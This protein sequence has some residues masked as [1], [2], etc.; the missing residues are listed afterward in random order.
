MF[1]LKELQKAIVN[2]DKSK[3]KEF[4][5]IISEIKN[6]VQILS[7]ALYPAIDEI[8]DSF[9]KK[10]IS[11]IELLLSLQIFQE[12]LSQI[13]KKSPLPA[14]KE[15]ILLGV[16]E[17]DVHDMG[18][19][20]IKEVYIC[21]GFDVYDVGKN[22]PINLFLEKIRSK[23][24]AIVGISTMMSTTINKVQTLVEKI[25]NEFKNT[26]V[27]VGGAFITPKIAY[28]IGADGY[29]ESASELIEETEKLLNS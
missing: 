16:I 26:K 21:Y 12:I 13:S 25:K 18:K 1:N 24:P 28:D 10:Q 23:R 22:V 7:E 4:L 15:K 11:I 20:I 8:R 5:P 2:R 3:V 29:A 14:R 19:N 9:R 6:P 17:G 27:M